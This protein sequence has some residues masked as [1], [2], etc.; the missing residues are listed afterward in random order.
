[1]TTEI[2]GQKCPKGCPCYAYTPPSEDVHCF[3]CGSL[4]IPNVVDKDGLANNS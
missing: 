2:L 3:V 4:M 1:M